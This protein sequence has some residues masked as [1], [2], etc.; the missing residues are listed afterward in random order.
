MGYHTE[1]EGYVAVSP[2]LNAAEVAYLTRFNG[3]RRW[4]RLTGP[5]DTNDAGYYISGNNYRR[6]TPPPDQ[7]G[8]WCPWTP[9]PDGTA[10]AWDGCEKPYAAVEWM[11]LLIHHFLR[12]EAVASQPLPDGWVR[13]CEFD[14][15][16]FNHSLTGGFHAQGAAKNDAW[17][18]LVR[19]NVVTHVNGHVPPLP[20]PGGPTWR[21][22]EARTAAREQMLAP[23]RQPMDGLRYDYPEMDP[24]QML[25]VVLSALIS[26]GYAV[27]APDGET[28]VEPPS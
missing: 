18:L 25:D 19:D 8:L 27:T 17:T 22:A 4:D 14:Q 9:T 11:N 2:P 20:V 21:E 24:Q 10:L 15:F 12:E 6:A 23:A 5:Y 16:T 1:F 26:A 28:R 3:S 7:P 13:P